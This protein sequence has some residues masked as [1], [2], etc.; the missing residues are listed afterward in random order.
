MTAPNDWRTEVGRKAPNVLSLLR[1]L[2][3]PVFV[4]ILWDPTPTSSL[5]A[6]G[7]FVLA[8]LT[9]WLD[10]YLARLY[11]AESIVG[12]LLD[13]LADKILTMAAL[14][15]LCAIKTDPRVPAWMVVLLLSREVIVT[16]LR[17]LA[18]VRGIVVPASKWAKHKTAWTMI[19]IVGLLVNEPYE[20]S[21][22]MINFHFSGMVFLWL[23]LLLSLGTGIAYAVD[24]RD[25]FEEGTL[26]PEQRAKI[27]I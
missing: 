27:S 23:A 9:D 7:L 25:I 11:Q 3:V 19:A 4:V 16:G 1:I 5:W 6:A 14:V 2:A 13:P 12:T 17:S 24:L 22:V 26:S 10:G 21:G 8:S 18:A 15:M 20:I